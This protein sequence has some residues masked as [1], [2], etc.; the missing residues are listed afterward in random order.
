MLDFL[1]SRQWVIRRRLF[2]VGIVAIVAYRQYGD[3]VAMWFSGPNPVRDITI[4]R[5]EFRPELPAARPAW[6]IGF[7]NDSAK[8]TYDNIELEATYMDKDG[9]VIE[10][11]KLV[12]KQ[13]LPPGGEKVIASTDFKSRGAAS[14]GTLSVL[15]AQE[16]R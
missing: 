5:S 4:T 15:G 3:S 2:L 1:C 12:V 8:F 14:R 6:I 11:D 7:R 9:K 10:T 13:K 16:T